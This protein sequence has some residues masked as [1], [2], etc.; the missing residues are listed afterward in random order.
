MS[1]R[2]L[3]DA[4]TCSPVSALRHPGGRRGRLGGGAKRVLPFPA[5]WGV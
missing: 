1:V 5:V 4:V 2:A 3:K